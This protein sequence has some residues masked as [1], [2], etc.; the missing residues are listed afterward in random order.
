MTMKSVF[1]SELDDQVE[2]LLE[3]YERATRSKTDARIYGELAAECRELARA[4]AA[5]DYRQAGVHFGRIRRISMD[6]L[7]ME[8]AWLIP[9]S[10]I[11]KLLRVLIVDA[12]CPYCKGYLR[13]ATARQCPECL[14]DWHDADNVRFLG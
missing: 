5:G 14:R 3:H 13:S 4:G 11:E 7:A 12:R 10:R 1:V 8:D 6:G 2:A 9:V